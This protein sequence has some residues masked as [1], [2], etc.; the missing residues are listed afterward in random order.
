M[1]KGGG[2][3]Q[4]E[5]FAVTNWLRRINVDVI[6][7]GIWERHVEPVKH[8]QRYCLELLKGESSRI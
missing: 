2:Q 7:L 3:I 8:I 1:T 6:F 5:S 4:D